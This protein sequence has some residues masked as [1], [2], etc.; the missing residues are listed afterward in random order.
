M[1]YVSLFSSAGVGCYGFS[2][3]GYDCIASS[4]LIERRMKVQQANNK[5]KYENGYILGDISECESKEKLYHAI[6]YYKDVERVTDIDV[7][8]FTAP[9]QGMSVANHKKNETT[10][11]KNSLVV[12]A[13]EIVYKIK[14]KIFVAENVRAF[15]NT[16]CIDNGVEKK[17]NQAFHDWLFEDYHYESKVVNFKSYGA[18]S[19]RTRTLAIGI[20]RD[21]LDNIEL[22]SLFPCSEEEKTLRDVIGDL[23]S[24]DEMGQICDSDIFHGFKKYRPDMREW[25]RGVTEG[26]SAFDNEDPMKRPHSKLKCGEIRMNTNKNGDKYTRQRWDGVAPCIHTRNDIMSSQNTVHPVDDRVFSIRELMRMMN[27]PNSFKWTSDDLDS[28]NGLS[29]SEKEVFLK[30]NEINIRQSIGEAV[31]TIIMQKIAHNVKEAIDVLERTTVEETDKRLQ[32]T[33]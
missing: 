4:E 7:V 11:N 25:I 22:D 30:K 28:L 29:S 14:P 31:P 12:E 9:C 15:M 24:L 5:V 3:E 13:L 10:I 19:S 26:E 33:A 18:N 1:N 6:D 27:I 16:K 20:R 8:I 21:L 17:I 32:F 2:L 23:P